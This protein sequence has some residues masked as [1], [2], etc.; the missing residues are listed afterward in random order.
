MESWASDFSNLTISQPNQAPAVTNAGLQGWDTQF[1]QTSGMATTS[2]PMTGYAGGSGIS[3][4]TTGSMQQQMPA[5][6]QQNVQQS[7][8]AKE[9]EAKL[10]EAAFSN[11]EKQMD[12]PAEIVDIRQE[13]KEE[14][15]IE[16]TESTE[17]SKIAS[18]IVNNI[19]RKN[20]KLQNSNF[21]MLMQQLSA[22]Q[23]RLDGDKFVDAAGNDIRNAA[24]AELGRE[25]PF[26]NP[27]GPSAGPSSAPV[28]E[29][30]SGHLP[31]PLSFIDDSNLDKSKVYSPLEFAQ[32]MAHS[33]APHPSSWEENYDF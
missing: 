17:L 4:Y 21:M 18:H 26:Q 8:L 27:I 20:E 3:M 10:F 5:Q 1:L 7:A 13:V 25:L 30:T 11:I 33:G 23:V 2:V 12:R 6:A 22:K 28:Q 31:D 14:V 24:P 9:T 19:D 29:N 16:N 32:I 15:P